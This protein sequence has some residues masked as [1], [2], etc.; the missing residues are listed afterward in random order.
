ME[1]ACVAVLGGLALGVVGTI[2]GV[3]GGFILV[4]VLLL[5]NPQWSPDTVTAYSFAVVA[6]NASSGA[7]SYWRAG[8]VDRFDFPY[9]SGAAIP[10]AIVGSL[11]VGFIPRAIFDA[12]FGVVLLLIGAWLLRPRRA[13]RSTRHES[14]VTRELVTR[15][16]TRYVWSF[17]L[18]LGV[19]GSAGVGF[20]SSILGIG[21]GIVHVP[22]LATVLGF[23]EHVATATSHAVL[24]V[25]SLVAATVHLIHGDYR[26]DAG[27]VLATCLGSLLG[28]PIG[29]HLSTRV[30]GHAILRALAVSLV[31]VGLRLLLTAYHA[32]H[33]SA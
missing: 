5:L 10:G 27:L 17:D 20:L 9:F 22:F 1:Q 29:A 4:P 16:G 15:D 23:P 33:A 18:G 24:A 26:S 32:A 31:F 13:L 7:T 8:R 14:G 6:A 12:L 3:G 30:P 25:T 2:I 19:L 11:V 28:A 21:G